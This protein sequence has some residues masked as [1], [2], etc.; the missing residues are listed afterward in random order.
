MNVRFLA[1]MLMLVIA[2]VAW[3]G[4]AIPEGS[5]VTLEKAGIPVYNLRGGILAW[6]HAG[7]KVYDQTG[8]TARVHVYGQEWDLAPEPY[9]AIW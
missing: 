2:A 8:E 6:I 1:P 4:G 9:E 3:G 5:K 7:G